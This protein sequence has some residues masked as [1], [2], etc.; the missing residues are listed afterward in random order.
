MPRTCTICAH[1]RRSE[2]DKRS[3]APPLG[4]VS[5]SDFPCPWARSLATKERHLPVTLAHAKEVR[6]AELG[7]S[8]LSEARRLHARATNIL[9]QAE[10]AGHL[11]TA[12][13]ISLL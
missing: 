6:E 3:Y 2:I 13:M 9:E 1:P 10:K 7:E 11:E 4:G 5:W 8:L 12:L